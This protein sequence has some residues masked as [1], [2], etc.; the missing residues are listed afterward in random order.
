MALRGAAG[1]DWGTNLARVKDYNEAVVLDHMRKNGPVA[2]AAIAAATGL[3]LQTVSNITRRLVDARLVVAESEGR[4][5]R[6]RVNP[7]A[8]FALGI[9]LVRSTMAVGVVDVAGSVRGRAETSFPLDAPPERALER[10]DGLV[11]Q[12]LAAAGI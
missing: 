7:D 3:T 2:R 5:G 1:R 11:E 4:G 6:F 10:L 12:A 8:A 9:H